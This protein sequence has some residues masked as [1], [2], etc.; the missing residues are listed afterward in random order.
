M[1]PAITRSRDR[2]GGRSS[3]ATA[4]RSAGRLSANLINRSNFFFSLRL[5]C[6][7]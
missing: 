7:S 5:T 1:M 3:L 2:P 4:R 6:L